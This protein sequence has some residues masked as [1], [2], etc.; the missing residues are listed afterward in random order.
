MSE[1]KTYVF[2]ENQCS[3]SLVSMLA[4]LLSQRGVDPGL[5][6]LLRNNNGDGWGNQS[7]WVIIL[8]FMLWG[9]NGWGGNEGNTGGLANMLN[10]DTGREMIMSAIQGNATAISQL[11]TSLN[12]DTNAIQQAINGI[13]SS[14]CQVGNQVGMS[15]QQVINAIQQGNMTI[16]SQLANCCCDIRE[17]VTKM[18][19]ENQLATANQTSALNASIQ[20]VGNRVERGFCDTAYETQAQTCAIQNAIRDYGTANTNAIVAKLDQMQTTALQD[21]IDAL[22]EANSDYKSQVMFNH[23][24]NQYVAPINAALAGLTKE[25]SDIQCKLPQTVTLPYSC[26]TAVPTCG[27]YNGLYGGLFGGY[28]GTGYFG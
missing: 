4:P 23:T 9:R 24:V 6:A 3:G 28:P 12:C 18:G 22:R 13:Q 17:S 14:V 27:L 20:N 7:W 16:A 8:L 10:N 5:L 21:K 25:V 15:G 2:G 1:A 19:Y 26:A 11:A